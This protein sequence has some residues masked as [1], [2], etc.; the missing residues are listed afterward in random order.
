MKIIKAD[1]FGSPIDGYALIMTF[2][3]LGVLLHFDCFL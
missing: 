2:F 1:R 3:I